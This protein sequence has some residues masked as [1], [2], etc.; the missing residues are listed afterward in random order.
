MADSLI[1]FTRPT[2]SQEFLKIFNRLCVALREPK[3]DTGVTQD[4]YFSALKDL[5]VAALRAAAESL[6]KETGRRFFPTSAEWRTA[7]EDANRKQLQAAVQPGRDEPWH[8]DCED[9]EDTGWIRLHCGGNDTCGRR[10]RHQ[11]HDYVIVCGCRATNRT[12]QRHHGP[13][14]TA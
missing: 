7:A 1:P 3:D 12:Y 14:A 10:N 5:P 9:C 8:F 11:P 6:A 13:G 2:A 4:V